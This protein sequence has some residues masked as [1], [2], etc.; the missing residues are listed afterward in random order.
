MQGDLH[1]INLLWE[2]AG[3][4]KTYPIPF[5]DISLACLSYYDHGRG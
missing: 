4:G 3:G 1:L 5:P 2:F